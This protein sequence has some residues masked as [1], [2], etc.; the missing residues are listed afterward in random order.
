VCELQ[1]LISPKDFARQMD[2]FFLL[3]TQHISTQYVIEK[4]CHSMCE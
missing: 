2:A 3:Y 1:P 4:T